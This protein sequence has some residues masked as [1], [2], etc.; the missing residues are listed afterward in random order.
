MSKQTEA[1]RLAGLLEVGEI[2]NTG[3]CHAAD[4]LRRLA[5]LNAELVEVVKLSATVLSGEALN[6]S[7]LINALERSVVVLAKAEAAA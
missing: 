5:E 2:S 4:E 1:E 3:M 7:A 6:K